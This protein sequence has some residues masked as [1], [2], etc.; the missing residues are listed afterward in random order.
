MDCYGEMAEQLAELLGSRSHIRMDREF[1]RAQRNE[2]SV[3][4]CLARNGAVHPKELSD[5]LMVSTA[6]TAVILNRLERKGLI[7]RVRDGGDSRQKTVTVTAAGLSVLEERRRI[8]LAFFAETL[9]ELGEKDA[10]EF[11]RLYERIAQISARQLE[12]V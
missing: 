8:L 5:L 4:H 7:A 11:L 6:R 1:S 3:L 12:H 9:R 2:I 10:R